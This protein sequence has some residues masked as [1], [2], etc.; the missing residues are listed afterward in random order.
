M[1]KFLGIAEPSQVNVTQHSVF[2]KQN[3]SAVKANEN[4]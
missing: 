3:V 4:F 1:E 2:R